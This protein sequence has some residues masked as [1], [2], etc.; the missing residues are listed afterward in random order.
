MTDSVANVLMDYSRVMPNPANQLAQGFARGRTQRTADQR[1]KLEGR[2]TEI[3]EA[4]NTREEAADKR[5][6]EMQKHKELAGVAASAN[7]PEKWSSAQELGFLPKEM[8]FESREPYIMG[9]M[10]QSERM[11]REKLDFQKGQTE[12]QNVMAARKQGFTEKQAGVENAMAARKQT[13]IERKNKAGEV[14]GAGSGGM[15]TDY[16]KVS[17]SNYF[18][19]QAGELLGGTYDA[20]TD[21]YTYKDSTARRKA[22]KVKRDA[23]QYR[24]QGMSREQAFFNAAQKNGIDPN[25]EGDQEELAEQAAQEP[26][27]PARPARDYSN[28]Y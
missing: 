25:L 5:S 24:Q 16:G 26:K 9:V 27:V 20:E 13:E 3:A 17:E 10:T 6:Q 18:A 8:A 21:K 1:T 15:S 19:K 22:V 23:A 11:N 4:R 28:L 12:T 14:S 2:R 7:T